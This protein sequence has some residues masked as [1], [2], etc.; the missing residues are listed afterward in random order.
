MVFVEKIRNINFTPL[1]ILSVQYIIINVCTL[2]CN[3]S[4]N[5]EILKS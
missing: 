5:F 3:S 2:L 1:T 4:Q